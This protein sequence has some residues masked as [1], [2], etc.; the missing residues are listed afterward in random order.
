MQCNYAVLRCLKLL[1]EGWPDTAKSRVFFFYREPKWVKS[2]FF[3]HKLQQYTL[4]SELGRGWGWGGGGLR[5]KQANKVRCVHCV[6]DTMLEEWPEG[7]ILTDY[8]TI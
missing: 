3:I 1:E 5:I 8:N 4:C 7:P 6:I 2:Q